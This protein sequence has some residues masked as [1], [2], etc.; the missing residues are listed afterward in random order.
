M[1]EV[2]VRVGSVLL[3]LAVCGL[4]AAA[5]EWNFTSGLPGGLS[6]RG[7]AVLNERGLSVREY[8][9]GEKAG[10][11]ETKDIFGFPAAFEIEV[12]FEV[13]AADVGVFKSRGTHV[14]PILLDSM[15]VN[16]PP[17][18]RHRGLQLGFDVYGDRWSPRLWLGLSNATCRTEGPARTVVPG[19]RLILAVRHDGG[20]EVQWEFAGKRTVV[21]L[22]TAG[23][24][25]PSGNPLVI[26]DRVGST[27]D[28]FRGIIRRVR[29]TPRERPAIGIRTCGRA[30]FERCEPKASA[31]V[32][33]ENLSARELLGLQAAVEQLDVVSNVVRRATMELSPT[34]PG[35]VTTVSVPLETRLR[36]GWQALRIS[37]VEGGRT[38]VEKTVRV[39]IGPL[40]GDVM[41]AL[42]WQ[43][44][45][46][47]DMRDFGFTHQLA[48][49]A[50]RKPLAEGG[51]PVSSLEFLDEALVGGIRLVSQHSNV[52]LPPD[53]SSSGFLRLTRTGEPE[54]SKGTEVGDPQL[55]ARAKTVASGLARALATHPA[56][57]GVL[58]FSELRDAS[59]PSFRQEHERYRAETGLSV[60]DRVRGRTLGWDEG[61]KLFP[62]GIVPEDD[63]VLSYY[64]WFWSGGDGW[65]GYVG[66]VAGEY[67]RVRGRFGDGSARQ[68]R[69]PFFSFW[70]PSVRCP[71]IWG[72]GGDVDV[73]NQWVY[74]YPEP[75]NVA[76]PAEEELAMAA[77]RPG[78]EAMIM[79]Q[80]ICYRSEIAPRNE[81]VAPEPD[82]VKRRPLA[83]FPSIPPDSLQ[84]ATW[85]MLSRPVKG[86][87]YHG[88]GCIKETGAATGYVFTNPDTPKMLKRLLRTV[89]RPLG[90]TLK[91][92]PRENPPVA[93][94]ESFTTAALGGPTTW[95]W[96]AP[97]V[98][99]LQRARLDPRVVY[100][101][102][103]L[104]DGLE[105]VK[106][107]YAPQCPLLTRPVVDR[108][109]AFQ[110]KGGI[111][112]ADEFLTKALKADI[113][114]PV[115]TLKRPPAM[116]KTEDV[117][118]QAAEAR[119][120]GLAR[121][122]TVRNKTEMQ[123]IADQLR[124]QLVHRF[125]PK[126][127]SSDGDLVTALRRWR[128]TDYLF[129]INDCRTFGD[130]VGPWGRTMERGLPHD[131]WASLRDPRRR[132]RAVYELSRHEEVGFSREG[133]SV[134]VPV[135]FETNDG[136]LLMFLDTKIAGVDVEV[137]DAVAR[138]EPLDVTVTVRG[139][140]GKPVDALIPLEMALQ[141]AAGRLLVG[142][143]QTVAENGVCRLRLRTNVNDASGGYRLV[144]REGASGRKAVR[145][146]AEAARK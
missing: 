61:V 103:V 75:L 88:F 35:E 57:G 44:G 87:M 48:E 145:Q 20:R 54:K 29:V 21:Q 59:V 50:L 104:R 116:D 81:R 142:C 100:E 129:V 24:V 9:G 99:M 122:V 38:L 117:E 126:A 83:D 2:R 95:G 97:A 140:N 36:P 33:F 79:T 70:D 96:S 77:G 85:A 141:D 94:L 7:N 78:Q 1:T 112:V 111:L 46:I 68:T 18:W 121:D 131:G 144:C 136:R 143:R 82:W 135:S 86:I 120:N 47:E 11:C 107:L 53:G 67:A 28:P 139:E 133:D 22:P 58:P 130:Y 102:T 134:R 56:M 8:P 14:T 49:F 89:V 124:R 132:V 74:A 25:C 146:I 105:D 42:M 138:G 4:S 10:G 43:G 92:L 119:V 71:P 76:G 30:A 84:E 72:S 26:G 62:D 73:L 37:V 114:L 34:A 51:D 31:K 60:P 16:Y 118:A 101:Q 128:E 17:N 106:V 93:V 5:A 39:G 63:P 127:D 6:A 19:E 125:A 69:Y 91:R 65:P 66:A 80:L 41:P 109:R 110:K 137:A 15:Y 113:V 90:P 52:F 108:I 40:V 64:R 23:S 98:T 3:S 45:S 27:Y 55:V 12:E 13:G 32:E 115:V 123:S